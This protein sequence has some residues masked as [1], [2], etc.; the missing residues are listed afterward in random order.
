MA[1]ENNSAHVLVVLLFRVKVGLQTLFK[2]IPFANQFQFI[3]VFCSDLP[4]DLDIAAVSAA[5]IDAICAWSFWVQMMQQDVVALLQ[6][7]GDDSGGPPDLLHGVFAE[8]SDFRLCEIGLHHV[9]PSQ[10]SAVEDVPHE[11]A[12]GTGVLHGEHGEG[13]LVRQGARGGGGG[14]GVGLRQQRGDGRV[15][16][17]AIHRVQQVRGVALALEGRQQQDLTQTQRLRGTLEGVR[18]HVQQTVPHQHPLRGHVTVER[19][20][21]PAV[22]GVRCHHDLAGALDEPVAQRLAVLEERHRLWGRQRAQVDGEVAVRSGVAVQESSRRLEL[23]LFLDVR[24]DDRIYF[25]N[26]IGVDH[27]IDV[28]ALGSPSPNSLRQLF[29]V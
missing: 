15:H 6:L 17:A 26:S 27:T 9:H 20:H 25:G 2:G 22:R 23:Q 13:A 19:Q 24:E 11:G 8:R 10:Q 28:A 7:R 29:L 14:G 3:P 21:Q 4:F 16:E 5:Y 12:L 18:K 1:L